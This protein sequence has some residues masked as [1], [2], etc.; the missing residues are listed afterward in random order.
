MLRKVYLAALLTAV[1]LTAA[2]S[3]LIADNIGGGFHYW[4]TIDD[5]DTREFN[6]EDEG[7]AWLFSYQHFL[8]QAVRLEATLEVL[9]EGF[10][11][12][13]DP[14]YSPQG[15]FLLGQG[16][17]IGIGAGVFY[18]DEEF[19]DTPFYGLRLGM[20]SALLG[21]LMLD[22]NAN[23]RVNDFSDL[24]NLSDVDTDTVTLGLSA[25][26]PL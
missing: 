23:Y 22:L 4:K 7:V 25:R 14:V 20:E 10:Y 2:R 3:P 11:G 13:D 9:P 8:N 17:Y 19:A 21:T 15:Y 26:I 5:L 16:M 12:R 6:V 1:L 24:G 18:V